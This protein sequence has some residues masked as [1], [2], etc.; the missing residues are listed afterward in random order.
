M[1]LHQ[2]LPK[3]KVIEW[4]NPSTWILHP[5]P[6][7]A[8][9]EDGRLD[10]S[11]VCIVTAPGHESVLLGHTST[12]VEEPTA[13][14]DAIQETN[15]TPVSW[16]VPSFKDKFIA[17]YED[18]PLGSK[19]KRLKE[20]YDRLVQGKPS[21]KDKFYQV[22]ED[23]LLRRKITLP[24]GPL[25]TPVSQTQLVVPQA[26]RKEILE[27]FHESSIGAHLGR[28]KTYSRLLPVLWW[29]GMFT[30]VRKHVATC[31]SCQLFKSTYDKNRPLF[32]TKPTSVW[33]VANIDLVGPFPLSTKG[34]KYIC[35]ITDSFTKWAEAVPIPDKTEDTV[36]EAIFNALICR[37]SVP[38]QIRTD[39]GSEFTNNLMQRL[40]SRMNIQHRQTCP[41]YPQA[42][43]HVER[44]N[45]TLVDCLSK[46]CHLEPSRW[47]TFIEGTLFAYRTS[48]VEDVGLSPFQMMYGRDPVLPIHILQSSPDDLVRDVEHFG[49][50]LTFNLHVMHKHVRE[51]LRDVAQQ[52]NERWLANARPVSLKPGQWILL[53]DKRVRTRQSLEYATRL[54]A[55]NG[56]TTNKSS[57]TTY[58]SKLQS[59]WLGPYLITKVMN[60]AIE[61]D[62]KDRQCKRVV[63]LAHVKLY[64][65]RIE[66]QVS[67]PAQQD[68]ITTEHITTKETRPQQD[69]RP[70]DETDQP[71]PSMV[72]PQPKQACDDAIDRLRN[73]MVEKILRHE[74]RGRQFWYF[75]KWYYFPESENSWIPTRNFNDKECLEEY[76]RETAPRLQ[77]ECI[78]PAYR[79]LH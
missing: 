8:E 56:D 54:L 33:H 16:N 7:G 48:R 52:R 70:R 29:P 17:A 57:D 39:Q 38:K 68:T 75:I 44:F 15:D 30:D 5:A 22:T 64:Q 4:S 49:T 23:G 59:E 46:Q 60:N 66:P 47:D 72:E 36:S 37:H 74:K 24:V 40:L 61:I 9:D 55:E 13:I 63:A 34:N 65:H 3:L 31:H 58:S 45:R 42:N 53:R 11:L 19:D 2:W 50:R 25:D 62:D 28:F 26:L 73:Y 20:T 43:G 21:A 6:D 78:P 10:H 1:R 18:A 79:H 69:K 32:S 12:T 77:P 27:M 35:V 67:E 71:C 41:Y 76:W 14:R 51:L